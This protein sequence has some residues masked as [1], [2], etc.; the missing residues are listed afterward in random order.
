MHLYPRKWYLYKSKVYH[1]SGDIQSR[2]QRK[3]SNIF[4]SPHLRGAYVTHLQ[5]SNSCGDLPLSRGEA[6]NHAISGR[7][8]TPS[9]HPRTRYL[10]PGAYVTHRQNCNSCGGP[11]INFSN[12]TIINVSYKRTITIVEISS[13]VISERLVAPSDHPI[14]MEFT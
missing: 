3:I 6:S 12:H 13:H 5:N 10:V 4:R 8:V 9:D 14:C 2:D 7:L 1:N 11:P